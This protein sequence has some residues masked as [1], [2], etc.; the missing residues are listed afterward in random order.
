MIMYHGVGDLGLEGDTGQPIKTQGLTSTRDKG[1][2]VRRLHGK[3]E[4]SVWLRR[5]TGSLSLSVDV[6]SGDLTTLYRV[7]LSRIESSSRRRW[8]RNLSLGK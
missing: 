5:G 1:S 4:D 3:E 8:V 2:W 7:S 6:R